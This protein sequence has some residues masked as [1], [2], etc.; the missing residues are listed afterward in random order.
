VKVWPVDSKKTMLNPQDIFVVAASEYKQGLE[1]AKEAAKKAGVSP[2]RMSYTIMV[3]EYSDPRLIRI[4]SGNTLFT[5][6]A[7]PDRTGF[8]RGYNGDTAPNYI[9]N[10]IEL[11]QSARKIGFDTLLAFGTPDV[12]RAIKMGMRRTQGMNITFD[13]SSGAMVITTGSARE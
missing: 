4:R 5:I 8:V 1:A 10:M 3:S 2:E 11:A 6:A 12:V 9:N 7:L 13:S